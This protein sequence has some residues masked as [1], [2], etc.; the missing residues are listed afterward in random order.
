MNIG[1]SNYNN[2]KMFKDSQSLFHQLSQ[3]ICE[4][5]ATP[6]FSKNKILIPMVICS[7]DATPHG[8]SCVVMH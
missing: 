5:D 4:A 3:V 8:A 2:I 6:K 1:W 7:R